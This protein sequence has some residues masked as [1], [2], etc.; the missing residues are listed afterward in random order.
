M[1]VFHSRHLGASSA[2]HWGDLNKLSHGDT[3]ANQGWHFDFLYKVNCGK[4]FIIMIKEDLCS[5]VRFFPCILLYCW[6][7]MTKKMSFGY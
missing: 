4:R 6:Y 3:L 5:E 2:G 7:F 1:R